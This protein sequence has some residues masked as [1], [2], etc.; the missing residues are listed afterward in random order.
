MSLLTFWGS[1]MLPDNSL[2]SLVFAWT[3]LIIWAIRFMAIYAFT[4]TVCT[5]GSVSAAEFVPQYILLTTGVAIVAELYVLRLALAP[6]A[7]ASDPPTG[8]FIN[9]LAASVAAMAMLVMAWETLPVYFLPI[10]R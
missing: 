2:R 5:L 9:G 6:L 8:I 7:V 10:C 1:K 3:G 4:A